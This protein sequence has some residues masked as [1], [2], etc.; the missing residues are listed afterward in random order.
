M[1][2]RE[3]AC[4]AVLGEHRPVTRHR[5][6]TLAVLCLS[7]LVVSIDNTV[8][9]V[10]LPTLVRD[11]GASPAQLQWI[12]DAYTLVFAGLLLTSGSLGDRFGRKLVMTIGLWVFGAASVAV[13]FADSPGRLIGIRA[14][15]GV[16]SALIMPATLSI[17]VSVFTDPSERRRAIAYWSLMNAAGGFFGPIT[18]GLMLRYFSWRAC[19]LVNIPFVVAA[20]VLGRRLVPTSRD[21]EAARFDVAGAVLSTAALA[22]VL[23]AIIEG[24]AKGWSSPEVLVAFAVAVA[25]GVAFVEWERRCPSP[26][27]DLAILRQP[28]LS[29]AS[30]T[31]IVA[32]V[33]LSG[34]MFLMS[35]SLQ[36]TKGYSPLM[37]ALA[38]SGP[39]VTVNFLL[40]P[41]TPRLIA[42][43][44]ARWMMCAG[45]ASVVV[46]ALTIS[47]TT[48]ESGY[49]NLLVGFALMAVGFS[50][51]VPSSTDAMMTAVPADRSGSASALNQLSRQVGQALGVAIC[52]SVAA[53]RYR[54]TFSSERAGLGGEA[55]QQAGRSITDAIELTR[56]LSAGAARAVMDAAQV[57]FLNGVRAATYVSAALALLAAL[58]GAIAIPGRAATERAHE[59]EVELSLELD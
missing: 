58:G 46:A 9:N 32:F 55:A 30:G 7:L 45:A 11:L 4:A 17:L 59:R 5:W 44:G 40:M 18:G 31:L 53:S 43:A 56:E 52:G 49:L 34:T 13:M 47:R 36:L 12:I 38:T 1:S 54:A 35:Q 3:L 37:A 29:A 16:G 48:V 28:Q 27:L 51:F 41:R 39:I 25:L 21:P 14:L 19:F 2:R 57:A 50:L 22:S 8:L 23:W 42:V 20:L 24:P 33:A 26:M 10:A 15:L 6:L